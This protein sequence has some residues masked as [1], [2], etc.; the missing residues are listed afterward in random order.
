MEEKDA[1]IAKLR[2]KLE[3]VNEKNTNMQ[4]YELNMKMEL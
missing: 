3:E 1:M 4:E 2:E